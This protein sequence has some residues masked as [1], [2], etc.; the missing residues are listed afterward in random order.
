[1]IKTIIT[2]DVGAATARIRFEHQDITIEQD[3]SLIDVVPGTRYVFEQMG[4]AFDEEHQ[5]LAITR[6]E[7]MIADQIDAG[8]IVSP[9]VV[10]AHDY[11]PPPSDGD[12]E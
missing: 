7:T 8:M 12:A 1:M 2:R 10:E 5:D 6:L 11:T 4:M 3:Y 9:P